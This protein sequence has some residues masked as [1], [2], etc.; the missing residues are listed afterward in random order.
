MKR[1]E[2]KGRLSQIVGGIGVLTVALALV[3]GT[4]SC[5]EET[6]SETLPEPDKMVWMVGDVNGWSP[7]SAI[8]M[9]ESNGGGFTWT[10]DI[11]GG[12]KFYGGET[13]PEDWDTGDTWYVPSNGDAA[14][15]NN[16][17][18]TCAV[19]ETSTVKAKRG[20]SNDAGAWQFANTG[21]YTI[22]VNPS[23]NEITFRMDV[24]KIEDPTLT[25]PENHKIYAI[26]SGGFGGWTLSSSVEFPKT[27]S[28]YTY[29]G[30]VNADD[31]FA[32]YTGTAPKSDW[33][34][35]T[36]FGSVGPTTITIGS[37]N[38]EV[39]VEIASGKSND[40]KSQWKIK[41]AGTYTITLDPATKKLTFK[42]TELA[43]EPEVNGKV[44]IVGGLN[45]WSVGNALE[46]TSSGGS[47]TWS[48]NIGFG[49]G[50]LK[51]YVAEEKISEWND[52]ATWLRPTDDGKEN[53][54]CAVNG[55][56]KTVTAA[57]YQSSGNSSYYLTGG[58]YT[59]TVNTANQEISFTK[60][61]EA[62]DVEVIT[63][64]DKVYAIGSG[65]FGGWTIGNSVEF[66]KTG[67]TYTYTGTVTA[68]TEF[69]LYTGT[70]PKSDWGADG[71]TW[72]GSLGS[73][74]ITGALNAEVPVEIA[75]G[76]NN[77]GKSQWKIKTAGTYTI[78]LDPAK[79][80]LTF[81]RTA[82]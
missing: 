32:L 21:T 57:V 6:L 35:D 79:A 77:D 81:K 70:A 33:D 16:E 50:E 40:G 49:K 1:I 23:S 56:A 68:D 75:S 45:D 44:W 25:I 37:L 61:A 19:G 64:T 71:D 65:G 12:V 5:G 7:A 4:V 55:G 62:S 27:E 30:T 41:T 67:T 38:E 58:T 53:V 69:A 3:F 54:S 8:S 52:P 80:L 73:G 28:T 10:G 46:M 36:W 17:T 24:A 34:G 78:T 2:A 63:I 31:E 66:P 82:D 9:T 13:K 74:D 18:V 43:E 51:F 42:L 26:G 22:T 48:G 11:S 76:K 47:F 59:I 72:F 39:A 14:N 15:D 29:T 60:T 20:K